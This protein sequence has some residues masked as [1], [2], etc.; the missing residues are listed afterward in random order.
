MFASCYL[1]EDEIESRGDYQT[2]FPTLDSDMRDPYNESYKLN[3]YSFPDSRDN[4]AIPYIP[5]QHTLVADADMS[6]A[7]AE[8]DD[9]D[10][11]VSAIEKVNQPRVAPDLP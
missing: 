3:E 4:I 9:N 6:A 1:T 5:V 10:M 7:S 2:I 8:I 11:V